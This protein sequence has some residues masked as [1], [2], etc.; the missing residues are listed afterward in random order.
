MMVARWRVRTCQ[1]NQMEAAV[2]ASARDMAVAI[3]DDRQHRVGPAA[4]L[5]HLGLSHCAVALSELH[6]AQHILCAGH[7]HLR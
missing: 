4:A 3:N 2:G 1:I 7:L 6:D 5:V